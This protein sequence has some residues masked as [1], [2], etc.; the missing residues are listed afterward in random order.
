MLLR[1][2][3]Q[4][5]YGL[6]EI[7]SRH[8][9]FAYF[10]AAGDTPAM[11]RWIAKRILSIAGW[12]AVGE[13]PTVRKAV[14][15]AAPHTSNWDGFWLL[16]YKIALGV[17]VRFLA[18]HT[19]FWWPLGPLLR[20]LGAI[21]IDRGDAVAIVPNLIRTFEKETQIYLAL[22]PEGTRQWMPYWKSGFHRIAQAANVPV[23]LAFIDYNKKRIG[24]G[25][26]LPLDLSL[27][28]TLIALREFYT[29]FRG[30]RPAS[31]GPIEFPP[32]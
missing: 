16:V 30:R 2:I 23:I 24:I 10:V 31:Q 5:S 14:F 12:T 29:P 9:F 4:T 27:D 11:L 13:P 3:C 7:L 22:A 26:S 28:D 8:R 15:I 18:K 32:D 1:I 6:A 25:K 17:D 20:A 21:P 19:L